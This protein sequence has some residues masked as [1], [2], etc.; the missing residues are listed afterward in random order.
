MVEKKEHG[1]S[2]QEHTKHPDLVRPEQNGICKAKNSTKSQCSL[3]RQGVCSGEDRKEREDVFQKE[4][5]RGQETE[6]RWE[7]KKTVVE[8]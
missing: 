2:Q 7:H 3:T 1:D 8:V 5:Q 6:H 4:E